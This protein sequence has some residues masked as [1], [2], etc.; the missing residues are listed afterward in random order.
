MSRALATTVPAESDW[1]CE[2]CGYVLNGLPAEGRCPECGKLTSESDPTL[3]L[4]PVWEQPAAGSAIKR[5]LVTTEQVLFQPT[6]FYRSLAT[7]GTSHKSLWFAQ[8]HFLIA[9]LLFGLAGWAHIDLLMGW[10]PAARLGAFLPWPVFIGL[11]WGTWVMLIVLTLVAAR[12]TTWEA[13]YR[14][15]RLP[16]GVVRRGMDYHAAHYLPVALLAAFTVIGYR[17]WL[18]RDPG[19]SARWG[20]AY[21]YTLCGEVIVCAGYLFKTYWIGMRNMMYAS[22]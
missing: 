2:G 8:M 14:G 15:L 5:L 6:R 3:R 12:L 9:S 11:A 16:L 21:L 7:R 4:P 13:T 19:H 10:G 18:M 22:R 20:A 1:L 17:W